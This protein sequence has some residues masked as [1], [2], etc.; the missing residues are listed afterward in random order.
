MI[1]S[2]GLPILIQVVMPV[3]VAMVMEVV[4]EAAMP[5]PVIMGMGPMVRAE[6]KAASVAHNEPL[7]ITC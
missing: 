5:V 7:M 3:V 6:A 1:T 2:E 4:T